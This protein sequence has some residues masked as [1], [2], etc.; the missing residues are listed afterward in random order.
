MAVV[1]F[2][3]ELFSDLIMGQKKLS[4]LNLYHLLVHC[5]YH[6]LTLYP[7]HFPLYIMH[8]QAR[9]LHLQ[10]GYIFFKFVYFLFSPPLFL[11]Y[12]PVYAI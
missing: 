2:V 10:V 9:V 12:C 8:L 6:I 7:S 11:S 4:S 1:V 3:C 5:K